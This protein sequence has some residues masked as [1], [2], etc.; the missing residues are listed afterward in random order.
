L[1]ENFTEISPQSKEVSRHT[2]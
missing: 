1:V 2:K